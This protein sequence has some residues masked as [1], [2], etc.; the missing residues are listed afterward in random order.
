MGHSKKCDRKASHCTRHFCKSNLNGMK[1]IG[2]NPA[3]S[4]I[5][6]QMCESACLELPC[7]YV[8]VFDLLFLSYSNHGG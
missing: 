4:T 5:H 7:L 6:G 2:Y 8:E 3:K 1:G